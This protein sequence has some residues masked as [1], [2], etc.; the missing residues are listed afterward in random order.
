MLTTH[1]KILETQISQQASFLA[2]PSDRLPNKPEPN[3]REQCNTMILR[4]RKQLK[5]PK[6]VTN[7]EYLH[8]KN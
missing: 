5:G 4:G 6:G 7:D 2:M 1:N 8:Y 3:P